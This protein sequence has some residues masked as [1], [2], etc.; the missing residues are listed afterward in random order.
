VERARLVRMRDLYRE[1]DPVVANL[2]LL[3][4]EGRHAEAV[5]LFRS[6]IEDRIDTE[7]ERLLALTVEE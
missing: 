2:V 4:R 3:E 6:E 7:F 1:I 5:A